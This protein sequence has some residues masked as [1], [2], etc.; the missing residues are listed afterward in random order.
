VCV[1]TAQAF[2]QGGKGTVVGHVTDSGGGVLQGARIEL[3]PADLTILTNNQGDFIMIGVTAGSY[4]LTITYVGF[5]PF[6]KDVTV[7]ADQTTRADAQLEVASK[8]EEILVTAERVHGEAEAINRTRT[9]ENILQVLP[10]EVITSLP[11]ANV[12]DAIGRLPSITLERDEGEGKYVQIRGTEPRYS[13]VTI[14]GVN[15]PAPESGVRQIKLDVIPSDIVESVEINKTLLA[16]MDGDGIGGSVNLRT[17]TAG[18]QPTVSIFGLGGYTPILNGR[19]ATQS[20]GTIGK[21]FGADKKLGLLIGGT[22]DWNG[23]G[24]DDIEPAPTA[25]QCDPGNCG[26]PSATAPYYPTYSTMDIREYEYYRARW[27]FDGSMDYKFNDH[28]S[29]YVRG[30]Y[31]HF[32]NFG[33]RWVLT[34]TINSFTT[35]PDQGGPDGN[36]SYNAQVRRP[37]Q[38][39]GSI[40]A[41]GRHDFR[42]SWLTW[43]VAASRASTE[44]H[45]YMTANFAP[46]DPASPLNNVQFL[47]NDS[48]PNRPKFIPQNGVNIYDWTQYFWQTVD[49]SKTYSPQVNLQAAASFA[50]QYTWGGHYGAF[51]FGAKFRNAHKFQNSNDIYYNV[52]DPTTL[53]L[54]TFPISFTNNN[55]YNGSYQTGALINF[56]T[57]RSYF[58]NNPSAFTIDENTTHQSNDP[59]NF[60]LIERVVA[61]YLMNTINFN[62][63]RLYTGLRFESTTED[64]LGYQVNVDSNGNYVSTSRLTSNSSHVVPLPS[65]ELRYALTSESALRFAYGRG[66]AR[67]NFGDLAPYLVRDDQHM[68]IDV[69]NPNLKATYADN[70]D[71]LYE[72]YLKPLGMIQGGWFYK[73]ITDPI[74]SVQSPVTTGTFAGYEQ[75]QPLNGSHAWLWGFEVAYQQ[76]MTYL[77]GYLSSLGISANYSYT[78]S[79]AYGVPGRSDNPPLQ[80]QAPNTF[81][82]SP[83]YDRGRVSVRMGLS[84]NQANVFQYNY[85]DGAPLGT[86]G[87]NGDVYLYTH[88]QVDAQ[89]SYRL[90]KGFSVVVYGL[91]LTNQVFGFYQGSAVY[92]IQREYYH[93][94]IGGGVRWSSA[95]EKF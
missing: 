92:P 35:N 54:S 64:V 34:P 86:T 10:T 36:M 42:T 26:S 37:V 94:T 5:S 22:Y 58:M 77:P 25:I 40:V 24:I 13:N 7:A 52:N 91:N 9:A 14:D 48:N 89:G 74:Y 57:V 55:Y 1:F 47:F 80:R 95:V 51:E 73:H 66:I 68:K 16:N 43:E 53:P 28:S 75:V 30:L 88:F 85:Q 78:K 79:K 8:A 69:G 6:T 72:Q 59:N 83:T 65:A 56:N 17:K 19:G 23:R 46:V 41:G 44:D 90:P 33:S 18:E 15:V 81:N 76:R 2:A 87:P 70:I 38:V 20:G 50:Q 67:P 63:I 11:N 62:R 12:A 49:N 84:Y 27:G 29:I 21:R 71:V 82:I 93:P 61:G 3:Q 60:D 32:D 4:K 39:I 31:S 45:G